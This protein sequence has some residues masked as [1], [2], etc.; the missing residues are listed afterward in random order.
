M[1]LAMTKSFLSALSSNRAA[2][3]ES[4]EARPSGILELPQIIVFIVLIATDLQKIRPKIAGKTGLRSG[5]SLI[6]KSINV[7]NIRLAPQP[8][9]AGGMPIASVSI[10]NR[11]ECHYVRSAAPFRQLSAAA[12]TSSGYHTGQFRRLP[13]CLDAMVQSSGAPLPIVPVPNGIRA[14]P[15]RRTPIAAGARL[16]RHVELS[17]AQ[18]KSS[19]QITRPA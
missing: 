6:T 2:T 18:R 16:T 12:A 15:S 11:E 8:A 4:A 9:R 5:G 19:R 14:S 1:T 10:G 7:V 13:I 17:L 3:T